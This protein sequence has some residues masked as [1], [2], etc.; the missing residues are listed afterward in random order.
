MYHCAACDAELFDSTAKFES[1]TGWPSF[2]EPAV[3]R[4]GRDPPSRARQITGRPATREQSPRSTG[5]SRAAATAPSRS[6]R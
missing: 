3:G 4:G 6:D 1:G 2:T 5:S